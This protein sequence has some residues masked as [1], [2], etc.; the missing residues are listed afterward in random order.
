MKTDWISQIV[1][2][3]KKKKERR[4]GGRE[5]DSL[6]LKYPHNQTGREV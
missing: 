5:R 2:K 4:G 3:N 1:T 6:T